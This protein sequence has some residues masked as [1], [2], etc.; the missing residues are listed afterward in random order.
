MRILVVSEGGLGVGF[1]QRLEKDGHDVKMGN[2]DLGTWRP[3]IVLYDNGNAYAKEADSLRASGFK[4]IGPSLWSAT[5]EDD[6]D[7]REQIITSLGWSLNGVAQGT[8]FYVSGWFNGASFISAY[9][10]V[11]Y[12]RFMPGGAGPDLM[13]TGMISCFNQL[14]TQTYQSFLKPLESVLKKVNHRGPVHIHAFV[15]GPIACVKE[16]LTSFAHPLSLTLFENAQITASEIILALLDESSKRIGTILPFASGIQLSL[17]P[18]PSGYSNEY[19]AIDGIVPG[20][21]KHIWLADIDIEDG[22]YASS[23][24]IGYVT[25]RGA[26][27]S[28]AIRRMY[29]T[30]GNLRAQ[31]LQYRNDIGRDI[32]PL[33]TSLR[34]GGWL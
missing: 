1:A 26:D 6:K 23:G 2:P 32:Q 34:R 17:P 25:A 8:N 29:R 33:L 28:E 19:K 30:V 11:I 31:D 5:I 9:T 7:Y 13:C 4:V 15:N 12:R 18:F 21:L 20:N 14:T 22:I 24:L 10:S 16:I 27:A 3:D